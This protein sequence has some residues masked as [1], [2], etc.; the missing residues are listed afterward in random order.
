MKV[1]NLKKEK[2]DVYIGRG[3]KWGNPFSHLENSKALYKVSSRNEA[4]EQYEKS[5]RFGDGK[6]LLDNSGEEIGSIVFADDN[7]N[8]SDVELLKQD[9]FEKH[10]NNFAPFFDKENFPF[11]RHEALHT[12][13]VACEL[14]SEQIENHWYHKS[15]INPKFNQLIEEAL[16]NLSK[17]YQCCDEEYDGISNK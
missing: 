2:Y 1:V 8:I 3:S 7:L 14:I 16:S 12:T 6:Y 4:I 17:A 9:L 11:Y 15:N 10:N 5:I 13:H